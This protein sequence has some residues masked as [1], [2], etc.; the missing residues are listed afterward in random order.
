MRNSTKSNIFFQ[1]VQFEVPEFV[2]RP[3]PDVV[4][5]KSV[6]Y[7]H[8]CRFQAR[9]VY[10]QPIMNR[11]DLAWRLDDD[12]IILSDIGY[13]IFKYMS[14]NGIVYGYVLIKRDAYG[15]LVHLWENATEYMNAHNINT[16]FFNT[17][18][19]AYVYYNNFEISSMALWRSREYQDYVEMVDQAGGIYHYRW[20]DAPIKTLAVTMFVPKSKTYCFSNMSYQHNKV[21]MNPPG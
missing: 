5:G 18:P 16:T 17:W 4:C 1:P 11:L 21:V 12:S 8:M 6:G 9:G 20:G 2:R 15:C 19:R 14:D 13:D 10:E 7:R 3:V